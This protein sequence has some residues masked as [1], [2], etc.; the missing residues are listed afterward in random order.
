MAFSTIDDEPWES[1]AEASELLKRVREL[2]SLGIGLVQFTEILDC[3]DEAGD[4]LSEGTALAEARIRFPTVFR[5]DGVP[6]LMPVALDVAG[7]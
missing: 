3:G 1:G 2:A 5:G 6:G 7:P 4:V